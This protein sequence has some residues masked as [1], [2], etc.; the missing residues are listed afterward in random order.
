MNIPA[1]VEICISMAFIYLVL[2]LMCTTLN[3]IVSTLLRFRAR[4]LAG[5]INAF[6]GDAELLKRF[7]NHGLIN[8]SV[9]AVNANGD[10]ANWKKGIDKVSSGTQDSKQATNNPGML[11]RHP[12]YL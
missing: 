8:A 11:D 1:V 3:E 7:Y 5:A 9:G 6:M 4:S 12:S 2:S 10:S